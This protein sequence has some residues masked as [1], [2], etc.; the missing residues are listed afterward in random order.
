MPAT[1]RDNLMNNDKG[2][3]YKT[4]RNNDTTP[5]T[6]G[7]LSGV[8]FLEQITCATCLDGAICSLCDTDKVCADCCACGETYETSGHHND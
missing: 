7:S 5:H 2:N 3:A 8:E 6:A 1:D 4:N